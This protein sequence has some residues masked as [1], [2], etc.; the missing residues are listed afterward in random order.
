MQIAMIG[1]HVCNYT[2]KWRY[3]N[4]RG[5][6]IKPSLAAPRRHDIP[7]VNKVCFLSLTLKSL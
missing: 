6:S 5:L 7:E 2:K 1:F 4:G 3:G